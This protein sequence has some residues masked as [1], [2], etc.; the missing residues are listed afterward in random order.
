M[1]RPADF[2]QPGDTAL[3]L[4]Q[5]FL[6]ALGNGVD[7]E[8]DGDYVVPSQLLLHGRA[9]FT[10]H[11]NG[12]RITL[13]DGAATGWGGS[14]LYIVQCEDFQVVDLICDGNRD[15]RTVVEDPAHVIVVD[16]C[17]RWTFRNVQAVNGT[18]DGFLVYAG[19]D[20]NGT[21]ANGAVA[22]ADIPSGWT[23]E[24]CTALNNFRQGLSI[25]EGI[26]AA[27]DG[28]RYG[29]T[30]GLWD[31]GNGPCAGINLEP[32]DV[33]SRP[34]D[35]IRD[36]ALRNILFDGN[37]GPG[38]L[39]T[40]T[41]GVR[42][43]EV[44]DCIFDTNKKAAIES[45]GDDV[46]ILRP[47]IRGWSNQ[48]YTS[49]TDAPPKRGAIDIGYGAGPTRIV[50]PVFERSDNGASDQNPCIYV[51]GG[52]AAGIAITGIQS[53]GSASFICGAHAPR[54]QVSHS[55]VDLHAARRP[56]AFVFLGDYAVFEHMM[57]L[58]VYESA[59]YFGGKAPR[60][61]DNKIYVRVAA[62]A[63]YVVAAW[64][65]AAPE[66][67]ANLVEFD[68][69]VAARIFAV[70]KDATVVDNKVFNCIGDRL[71]DSSGAPRVAS[72]NARA[73]RRS[74]PAD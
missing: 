41:N 55:V 40:R 65:A 16:K 59:A 68:R 27:V 30:H 48:P 53:D 23:L 21:G 67:R 26:D 39:I 20:G 74:R 14:A 35:R 7:G 46:A 64:D 57:L 17:H 10:L 18:C 43:I 4:L 13:A 3:Q 42:N 73:A 58:G 2:R 1:I 34:R 36:I 25:I 51:H 45:F 71:F 9:N 19:T 62:P 50:D 49:R 31:S 66:L 22:V 5:R 44:A 29:L 37:Q 32:D 63:T 70:G 38:L 54:I 33:P 6:D 72:G 61:Q 69:P 47:K 24:N 11:G 8:I 15:L 52:A 56:N 28:G 12:H 60:V